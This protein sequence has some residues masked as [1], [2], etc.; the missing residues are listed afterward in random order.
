MLE[1]N[2]CKSSDEIFPG[3][4]IICQLEIGHE[5]EHQFTYTWKVGSEDLI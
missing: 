4:F 3:H 2:N 5:G 1:I